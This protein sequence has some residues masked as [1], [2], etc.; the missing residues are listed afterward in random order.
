MCVCVCVCVCV[1]ACLCAE[2]NDF[3][4]RNK[5]LDRFLSGF[6]AGHST[7]SALLRVS[8]DY[9]RSADSGSRVVLLLLDLTAA[10]DT[11]D[12]NILILIDRFRNQV[13]IQGLAVKWFSSYLKDRSF[14]VSLG[15]YS[16]TLVRGVPQGSILGPILFSLYMLPSGSML[17]KF[18]IHYHLYA[19]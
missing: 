4:M 6:R 8:N 13:G 7:E 17:K 11:V 15:D 18:G 3:L 10:F 9:L 2:L 19:D 14:L 16:S 1:C 5:I 12:H